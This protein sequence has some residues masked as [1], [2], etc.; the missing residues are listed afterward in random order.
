MENPSVH[1]MLTRQIALASLALTFLLRARGKHVR[2]DANSG[3][4]SDLA[5]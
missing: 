3:N 5:L 4:G 1:S 2:P